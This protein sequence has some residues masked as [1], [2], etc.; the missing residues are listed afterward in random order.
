MPVHPYTR[1]GLNR[2]IGA[3]TLRIGVPSR[4]QFQEG[5][6]HACNTC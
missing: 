6:Y 5:E 3:L 4:E 1:V 2:A